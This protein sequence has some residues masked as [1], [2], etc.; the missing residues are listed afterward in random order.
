MNI[1][2]IKGTYIRQDR[3]KVLLDSLKVKEVM[4]CFDSREDRPQIDDS[5]KDLISVESVY[6]TDEK[7]RNAYSK[8]VF[9]FVFRSVEQPK[10]IRNIQT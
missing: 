2:F 6:N 4:L 9:R 7:Y 1:Y 3:Q 8:I 10:T 5:V